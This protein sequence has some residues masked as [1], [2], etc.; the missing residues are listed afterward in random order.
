M[1]VVLCHFSNVSGLGLSAKQAQ[2]LLLGNL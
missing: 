2:E 1:V